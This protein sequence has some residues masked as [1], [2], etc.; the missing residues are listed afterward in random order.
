MLDI[1]FVREN[2]DVIR[3]ENRE[4]PLSQKL[5][6]YVYILKSNNNQYYIGATSNIR[7]RVKYHNAGRVRSTKSNK[8]WSLIYKE[9]Y[10]TLSEARSREKQIKS[11]KSRKA[12]ERLKALSSSG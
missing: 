9:K 7:N 4:T 5:M 6:Y 3:K 12:I 10:N 2:P 8:P 1:K 11:W